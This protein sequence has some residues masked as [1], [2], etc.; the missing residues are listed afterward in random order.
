MSAARPLDETKRIFV[1]QPTTL[2]SDCIELV[3]ELFLCVAFSGT[4]DSD[5]G[6]FLGETDVVQVNSG[7]IIVNG[8]QIMAIEGTETVT[9]RLKLRFDGEVTIMDT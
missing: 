6:V 2:F 3:E 1:K 4:P 5:F 7:A 9:L 8:A